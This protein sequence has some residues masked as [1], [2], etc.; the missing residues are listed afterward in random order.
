MPSV[1]RQNIRGWI[2]EQQQRCDRWAWYANTTAKGGTLFAHAVLPAS[3][4]RIRIAKFSLKDT[5]RRNAVT[6]QKL[7]TILSSGGHTRHVPRILYARGWHNR[8][9]G[10]SQRRI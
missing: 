9:I 10:E 6:A 2:G 1:Q 4:Q 8:R 7:P 5:A 3:R